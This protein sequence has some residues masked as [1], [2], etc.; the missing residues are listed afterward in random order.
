MSFS[1]L[2]LDDRLLR[3]VADMGFAE[4]MPI[5]REAIPVILA[6]HDVL[7]KAQ[8]GTG[9]TA[10]FGL[11]IL[12]RLLPDSKRRPRALILLPTR[13]LT[14][15]VHEHLEALARHTPLRGIAI[16]GG[17]MDDEKQ[18]HALRQGAD[19]IAAT[20]GRLLRHLRGNYVDLGALE[21]VVLDEADQLLEFGFLPDLQRIVSYL[22]ERRQTLM[23]SATLPAQMQEL[24]RALLD[25]PVRI[26][27][28]ETTTAEPVREQLWPVAAHQKFDLLR[29][30]IAR[31][32]MDSVLV[33]TRT[34]KGADALT[35]ALRRAGLSA[36]QLH[37]ERP[38]EE[39]RAALRAFREGSVPILVATNLASRGLDITGISHVVNYDVPTAPEDYIHRVGRT[40][41]AGRPGE[42][43]TL[44]SAEEEILAAKIE[45][46][47]RKRLPEHRLEGFAYDREPDAVE[48]LKPRRTRTVDFQTRFIEEGK[49]KPFTR[50]GQLRRGFEVPDP[51]KEQRKKQK[52]RFRMKKRL[53]HEK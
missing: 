53:P 43:I 30:L 12:E 17:D 41:R 49:P 47:T 31:R 11:P 50:S 36:G 37:A 39:R 48:R 42:A 45:H 8:T 35:A 38:M 29:E 21:F 14:M 32:G 40:G 23:F 24:A 9:K 13:E 18:E 16:T 10:A 2:N 5:Q 27:I 6:G 33:F 44:M 4:P 1:A 52:K 19:W 15:Q 22:P 3:A 7:G 20:P 28:G 46:L 51:D 34:R 25:K 26:D